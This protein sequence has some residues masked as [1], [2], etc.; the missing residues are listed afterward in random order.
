MTVQFTKLVTLVKFL[1]KTY[2][3]GG[4]QLVHAQYYYMVSF[5]SSFK[6]KYYQSEF[7]TFEI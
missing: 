2:I 6:E 1:A 3:G 7:L 5:Y 4:K